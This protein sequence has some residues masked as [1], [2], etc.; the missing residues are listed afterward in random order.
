MDEQAGNDIGAI[1]D[2]LVDELEDVSELLGQD[3]ISTQEFRRTVLTFILTRY[4]RD[5]GEIAG[6]KPDE[7]METM[8]QREEDDDNE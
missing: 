7:F 8:K 2:E 4:S 3:D 5:L 6:R 1:V